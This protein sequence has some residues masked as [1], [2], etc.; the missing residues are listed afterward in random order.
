MTKCFGAA[1]IYGIRLRW[2]LLPPALEGADNSLTP[3]SRRL[4]GRIDRVAVDGTQIPH[5]ATGRH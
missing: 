1:D 4:L 3:I 5:S 2:D